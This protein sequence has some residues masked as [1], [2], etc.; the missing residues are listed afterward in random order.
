[1][2]SAITPRVPLD[3]NQGIV[4]TQSCLGVVCGPRQCPS[5]WE[6]RSLLA[7]GK[8]EISHA[9]TAFGGPH[10]QVVPP[11]IVTAS[12]S[13]TIHVSESRFASGRGRPINSTA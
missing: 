9:D 12:T 4:T 8:L 2:L 3:K 7:A 10:H 13:A 1:M 6:D 11:A 5:G